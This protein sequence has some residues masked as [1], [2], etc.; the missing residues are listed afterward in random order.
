MKQFEWL[1]HA[2]DAATGKARSPSV[3]RC[4]DEMSTG[5]AYIYLY[6]NYYSVYKVSS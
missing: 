5:N 1:F 4:N 2:R 6:K 3:N